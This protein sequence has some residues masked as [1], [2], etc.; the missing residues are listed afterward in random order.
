MR[1]CNKCGL[2]L[3]LTEFYWRPKRNQHSPSCK[4]CSRKDRSNNRLQNSEREKLYAIEYK[5]ELSPDDYSKLYETCGGVCSICKKASKL[6]VDHCHRSGQVRG[7]L[8]GQ[9][10]TMLGMAKDSVDTLQSAILYLKG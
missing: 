9:C 2:N 4:A 3:P 1:P 7:L 6:V 10:N 5:Y 8:C